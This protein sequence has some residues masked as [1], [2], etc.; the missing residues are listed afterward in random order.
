[1]RHREVTGAVHDEGGAIAL[2]VLHA[3]R[4]GYHPF[5]VSRVATRSRRSR[6][7]GR[8]RCRPRASTGPPPTSRSRVALAREGGLRRRRDHGLR[9][10]PDQPVPR[11]AHQRP[12]RRAGAAR[13]ANRMRFPVEIVRRTRELVGDG[14]PDRLPDLAARPRR[15][16]PDLGRGRRARAPARGGRRHRAQHRHRLARG[17]G[18]DDHH[19]GA[20][21]AP[22]ARRP[23]GSRPR[24]RSRSAPRT[25]S[26]PPSWPRTILAAG[27]ADLVSMARPLLADPDFVDKAAAGRA[28]EINTCIACNQACLDHVFANQQGVLPGQPARLPRDRAGAAAAARR[29]AR[30]TGRGR[31]RRARPG[32][33][34]PCRAA[35]RGFAVTLF[36]KVRRA[37]RPVPAGDGGARQGGLRRDAALLHAAGSRCSASTCG[38]APRPRAADLA[39]Y[40]EVVVATGVVPRMPDLDGHRPPER[41]VV[42]RRAERR[43]RPGPPG[44]GDRRRRHRRRRQ[45]LPRPTTRP[46]TS[47][48]GWR[49]GASATRPCTPAG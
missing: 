26:T 31:R 46:T 40:D 12:H 19:P 49:T 24:C 14:L 29:R 35:E 44:R 33:P 36:E 3:G 2:Q 8:A 43:G 7:S 25:G 39:A 28:D 37:R 10:L 13:R 42:R 4:Y 16:R 32:W 6:R 20:A 34:P 18:A 9:G 45:P 21:A 48:T 11:R 22:G 5:S 30:P 23:P 15:G 1:M 41:G 47:T 38:S 17:P 27:E